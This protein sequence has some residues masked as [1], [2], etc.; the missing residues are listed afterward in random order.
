MKQPQLPKKSGATR[1]SVRVPEPLWPEWWAAIHPRGG[2]LQVSPT[3]YGLRMYER[4]SDAK[5][6]RIVRVKVEEL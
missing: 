1:K 5:K 3:R 2:V 6:I 4:C